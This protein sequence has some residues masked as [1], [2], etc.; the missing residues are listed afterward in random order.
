MDQLIIVGIGS[1]VE[2]LRVKLRDPETCHW[3][4]SLVGMAGVG[5]TTLANQ[6]YDSFKTAYQCCAWVN[7]SQKPN[8][9]NI[10][11]K[12]SRQ[13]QMQKEKWEENHPDMEANPYE[14]LKQKRYLIVLDDI[15]NIETWDAL[16][17]G[18]PNGGESN[19]HKQ[20]PL[21]DE[22]SWELFSKIMKLPPENLD[23]T[24]TTPELRDAEPLLVDAGRPL[25]KV[26][27]W[28]SLWL[29]NRTEADFYE[30]GGADNQV[31]IGMGEDGILQYLTDVCSMVDLILERFLPPSTMHKW[32]HVSVQ[33]CYVPDWSS[34]SVYKARRTAFFNYSSPIFLS[35]SQLC[36]LV[37]QINEIKTRNPGEF[38]QVVN[39]CEYNPN[40]DTDMRKWISRLP[41]P[42]EYHSLIYNEIPD[43]AR[44]ASSFQ[45]DI[46]ELLSPTGYKGFKVHS[47]DVQRRAST[48]AR[49]NSVRISDRWCLPIVLVPFKQSSDENGWWELDYSKDLCILDAAASKEV[50]DTNEAGKYPLKRK[51][52]RT[53][54]VGQKLYL[55]SVLEAQ[56]RKENLVAISERSLGVFMV[57]CTDQLI[58][59]QM[60]CLDM[61]QVFYVSTVSGANGEVAVLSTIEPEKDARILVASSR[62]AIKM[63]KTRKW[64][65]G[66]KCKRSVWWEPECGL[67]HVMGD[68]ARLEIQK[69]QYTHWSGVMLE[70]ESG[71][72]K[73]PWKNC[74]SRLSF[75]CIERDVNNAAKMS[76]NP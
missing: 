63:E 19:L 34:M 31:I 2:E 4:T 50:A 39:L 41:Q 37:H 58:C 35:K 15:W 45:G 27:K 32:K 70:I 64:H 65:V 33:P 42:S 26:Q 3:I 17:I 18:I 73:R 47:R 12:I 49:K 13:V 16:K 76:S 43:A 68:A 23:E 48:G 14:F 29:E 8:V 24:H 66:F 7:V 10:L 62:V 38:S 20:L 74:S 9:R 54:I 36:D 56:V 72:I 53:L 11:R 61:K 5:K 59:A 28:A 44:A 52:V 40:V 57:L 51:E 30:M 75:G 71:T 60:T 6:V 22:E 69:C 1:H 46:V 67:K 55:C 21:S 25:C